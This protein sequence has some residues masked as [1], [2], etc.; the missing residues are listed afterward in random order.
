MSDTSQEMTPIQATISVVAN[1]KHE[2][3]MTLHHEIQQIIQTD[4]TKLHTDIT[5]IKQTLTS[6]M[7]NSQQEMKHFNNN[8]LTAR[9]S[10]SNK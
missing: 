3:M 9:H 4:V 6:H 1:L 2:V 7:E 8:W 5:A 10:F